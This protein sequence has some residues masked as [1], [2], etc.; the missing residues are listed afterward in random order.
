M[1]LNKTTK[2]IDDNIVRALTIVCE[3]AKNEID[4]FIWL[5]HRANY[6]NFP[7]SLV[8][9]CVFDIDAEITA[10]K[11]NLLDAQLSNSIQKQL[12]KIG[13]ILKNIKQNVHFDSE[14]ACLREN[15]GQWEDRL[16]LLKM[17]QKPNTKSN[18]FPTFN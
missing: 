12:L 15:Q 10:L 8:V 7:A 11:E 2:K 13:I 9:T 6:T 14:E 16:R 1:K 5:T 4:G 3:Q 18:N 17:K